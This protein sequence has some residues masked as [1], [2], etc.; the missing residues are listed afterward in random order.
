M[1]NFFDSQLIEHIEVAKK[2]KDDVYKTF[3]K[4]VNICVN[5]IKNNRKILFFGNGGSAV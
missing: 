4:V 1:K 5:A 2:T 3:K